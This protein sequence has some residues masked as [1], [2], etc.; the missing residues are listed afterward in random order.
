MR[1]IKFRAWNKET[2][3]MNKRVAVNGKNVISVWT[4]MDGDLC[5]RI[6]DDQNNARY[7]YIP[8]QYTD[9]N[10]VEIY[11]GDIVAWGRY[12]DEVTGKEKFNGYG[13][14]NYWLGD[15]CFEIDDIEG[16]TNGISKVAQNE[17]IGNIY[18]NK[19]LLG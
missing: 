5:T 2:K 13:V 18:E 15:A 11:E 12:K 8:M 10:G 4:D 3:E 14:V 19:E 6:L 17:V 7:D 16:V 1:E 9:K